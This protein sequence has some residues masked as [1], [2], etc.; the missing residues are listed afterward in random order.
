MRFFA[1]AA[2]ILSFTGIFASPAPL[3]STDLAARAEADLQARRS[4]N[5]RH[6]QPNAF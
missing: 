3:D 2:T 5:P 6:V 4:R 1:I